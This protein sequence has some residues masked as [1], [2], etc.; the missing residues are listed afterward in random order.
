ML[1]CRRCVN[2]DPDIQGWLKVIGLFLFV[3]HGQGYRLLDVKFLR[4]IAHATNVLRTELETHT[5]SGMATMSVWSNA[6]FDVQ[7]QVSQLVVEP[8]NRAVCVIHVGNASFRY[9]CQFD[10]VF[11]SL[12]SSSQPL[13]QRTPYFIENKN[14]LH[15]T[16]ENE[17]HKTS[18][19]WIPYRPTSIATN[20]IFD[21]CSEP[22]TVW[23]LQKGKT[24]HEAASSVISIIPKIVFCC[25]FPCEWGSIFAFGMTFQGNSDIEQCFIH[26]SSWC[27]RQIFSLLK[28]GY[29]VE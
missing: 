1:T 17:P 5:L 12:V 18:I 9:W 29:P 28:R 14:N 25:M 19:Y 10:G 2:A 26:Q 4:R 16:A 8:R 27:Q 15:V 3:S 7:I 20:H 6:L 21:S 23:H 11:L 13:L 22:T 24:F